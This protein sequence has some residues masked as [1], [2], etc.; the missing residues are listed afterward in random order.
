MHSVLEAKDI[1][2]S[3]TEPSPLHILEGI[4][5]NAEKGRTIAIMGAS[6]EGKSTLLHILGT[7]EFP[8]KGSLIID[9]KKVVPSNYCLLRNQSIG[10]IFQSF[11]LFENF[12]TLNNILMPAQI[13]RRSIQKNSP[14]YNRALKLID[15]VGLGPRLHY[16]AKMLS[17]GE[18]QRVCIA[19]ALCNN[20][21][22]ILADEPTGNLDHQTS[23]D[24]HQLLLSCVR[25]E[26]KTLIVVTHDTDLAN[27]CDRIF[28]LEKGKLIPQKLH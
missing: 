25:E 4:S 7:L 1:Y 9:D 18:R 12:T 26:Q 22:L 13:A 23:K 2:K 11:Y 3:F 24:I 19:R 5:L 10:F 6:G 14:A 15:R 17:G 16:Q 27:A 8:T 21:S 20:P 28:I